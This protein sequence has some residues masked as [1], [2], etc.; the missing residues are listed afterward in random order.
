METDRERWREA[1]GSQHGTLI[2]MEERVTISK[3]VWSADIM[4]ELISHNLCLSE[5]TLAEFERATNLIN[6][7]TNGAVNLFTETLS[8]TASC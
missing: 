3:L 7:D 6:S 4:S 1:E 8:N 5:R 2:R